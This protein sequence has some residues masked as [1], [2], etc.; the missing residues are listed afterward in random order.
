VARVHRNQQQH[1]VNQL[2]ENLGMMGLRQRDANEAPANGG[3]R[4][5][6]AR[7]DDVNGGDLLRLFCR[8]LTSA[9]AHAMEGRESEMNDDLQRARDLAER[10]D[11]RLTHGISMDY[12]IAYARRTRS[13][14]N[15]F[16]SRVVSGR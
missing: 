12:Y 11:A 5:H 3:G 1:N 6:G 7:V 16:T 9:R 4:R 15:Q 2:A 8:L 14:C 10:P 13:R